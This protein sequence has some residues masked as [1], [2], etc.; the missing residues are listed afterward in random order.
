MQEAFGSL[1]ATP[2]HTFAASL[3]PFGGDDSKCRTP[4]PTKSEALVTVSESSSSFRPA[5]RAVCAGKAPGVSPEEDEEGGPALCGATKIQADGRSES[6]SE[7]RAIEDGGNISPTDG[8]A[9]SEGE[10]AP[11]RVLQGVHEVG[12]RGDAEARGRSARGDIG[13][14]DCAMCR[15]RSS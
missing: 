2:N 14:Y 1:S 8:K 3:G 4:A 12:S 6:G 5:C 9:D 15:E 7:A 10:L 13:S 11:T